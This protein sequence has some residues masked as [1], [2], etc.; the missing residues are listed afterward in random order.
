[1][2]ALHNSDTIGDS[3]VDINTDTMDAAGRL[4]ALGFD[5]MAG[6]RALCPAAMPCCKFPGIAVDAHRIVPTM[7]AC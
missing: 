5:T 4:S 2:I 6:V 7:T 1:M 3:G